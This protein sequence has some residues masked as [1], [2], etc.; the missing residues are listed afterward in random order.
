M[1]SNSR[2]IYLVILLGLAVGACYAAIHNYPGWDPQRRMIVLRR[3]QP[4]DSLFRLVVAAFTAEGLTISNADAGTGFVTST[5]VERSGEIINRYTDTYRATVIA[6]GRDS[7]EVLLSG[8]TRHESGT[9][10]P[11]IRMKP[12]S[13]AAFLRLDRIA[14]Q[15]RQ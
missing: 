8:D 3:A 11:L 2:K 13:S 7:S 9:G 6:L 5:P 14:R 1:R 12:D 15:L 4:R 10:R